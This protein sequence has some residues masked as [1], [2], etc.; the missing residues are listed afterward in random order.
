MN[1][2][3]RQISLL[4]VIALVFA[5]AIPAFGQL[6]AV[7]VERELTSAGGQYI[8]T[9]PTNVALSPTGTRFAVV[10]RNLERVF[11][12]DTDGNL[13]WLAGETGYLPHPTAVAFG[14]E[15]SLL[16]VLEDLK[17]LRIL[18]NTPNIA[19]T[20]A[21]LSKASGKLKVKS[22]D[23]M[24]V[25]GNSYLVLD[26]TQGQLLQ[27]DSA[28]QAKK[29]LISQGQGKGR[30]YEPTG[31]AVDIAGKIYASDAANLPLQIFSPSGSFLVNA[32][33]SAPDKQRTWEA[34]AVTITPQEVIWVADLTNRTWRLYDQTGN[35]I[36]EV[37]F[38]SPGFRPTAMLATSD[39]RLI[40]ADERGPVYIL[41]LLP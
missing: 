7:T 38:P 19:D 8:L 29:V 3:G 1:S 30:L 11:V 31:F 9:K 15:N 40:V 41:S 32:D 6:S 28:W 36:G 17:V 16:V 37:A 22:V 5:G 25:S 33:W 26:R 10:D 24:M 39:N 21:E 20:V 2:H 12:F 13:L 34:S 35:A 18:E 27:L 14:E 23:Q 4:L